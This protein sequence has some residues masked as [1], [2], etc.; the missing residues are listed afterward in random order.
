MKDM[1]DGSGTFIRIE[2]PTVLQSGTV[3][4]VGESHIIVGL[5][6]DNLCENQAIK[7]AASGSIKAPYVS[8][9]V[10]DNEISSTQLMLKFIRGPKASETIKFMP[11]D[12]P[13]LIGRNFDCHI[14]VASDE[15]ISRYQARID[16]IDDQWILRDGNGDTHSPDQRENNGMVEQ[17][18]KSDRIN[19]NSENGNNP[20]D[21]FVSNIE[22]STNG[23]WIFCNQEEELKGQQLIKVGNSFL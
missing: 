6:F 12:A 7:K 19:E 4:C 15:S 2:E 20:N 9:I 14:Q 11:D 18:M 23:T 22:R 1:G 3:I 5:I 8:S 10:Q 16:H 17:Q 21:S 13:I